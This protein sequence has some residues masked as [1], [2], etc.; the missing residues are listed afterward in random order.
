MTTQLLVT[1]IRTSK[2]GSRLMSAITDSSPDDGDALD[3]EYVTDFSSEGGEFVIEPGSQNEEIGTYGGLN[4]WTDLLLEINRPDPKAHPAGAVV[5]AGRTPYE[6]KLADGFV[7]GDMTQMILGAPIRSDAVTYYK[8]GAYAPDDA[9]VA[10]VE[11]A[12]EDDDERHIASAPFG[13]KPLVGFDLETMTPVG[14]GDSSITVPGPGGTVQP[15][16]GMGYEDGAVPTGDLTIEAIGGIVDWIRVIC[17]ETISNSSEVTYELHCDTSAGFTIGD[18]TLYDSFNLDG[19]PGKP[20]SFTVSDFPS[21]HK[22]DGG[23][24]DPPNPDTTYFFKVQ[25][26]DGSGVG[27]TSNE[28]S[29]SPILIGTVALEPL[30]ITETLIADD[31]I[32]T[33]KLQANAVTANEIAALSIAAGHLQANSVVSGKVAAN[34]IVASNIVGGTIT[35]AKIAAGTITADKLSVDNLAAINADLGNVIAGNIEGVTITGGTFRTAPSGTRVEIRSGSV[36]QITWYSGGTAAGFIRHNGAHLLISAPLGTVRVSD[37]LQVD[38]DVGL[39]GVSPASRGI[40][41]NLS[42]SDSTTAQLHSKLNNL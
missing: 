12:D 34:A 37:Q 32:S 38:G 36:D 24:A 27:V 8:P 20:F 4:L 5:W 23:P 33:P 14:G 2:A 16:P 10:W 31:A 17:A 15:P 29:A 39:Y 30:S 26:R 3:V 19:T 13:V 22:L 42:G 25:A 7:D 18:D 28:V 41:N 1:Q 40:V 9:L 11:A 35:G 6:E 21:T